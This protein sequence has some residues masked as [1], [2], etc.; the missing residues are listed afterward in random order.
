MINSFF[1]FEKKKSNILSF[2]ISGHANYSKN[3]LDIVCASVSSIVFGILN[4]LKA[5][6]FTGKILIEDNEIKIDLIEKDSNV[7]II[8]QTLFIQL[9]TVADKYP[10]NL[11][12]SEI[13]SH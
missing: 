6:K 11:K 10:K 5:Y 3:D 13:Y 12:I 4:S 1:K 9:K 8:L 7:E 2:K